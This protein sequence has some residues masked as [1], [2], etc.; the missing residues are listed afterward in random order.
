MQLITFAG[1]GFLQSFFHV[2]DL[3]EGRT[4]FVHMILGKTYAGF[5]VV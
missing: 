5:G 2:I 1:K 3:H 4:A